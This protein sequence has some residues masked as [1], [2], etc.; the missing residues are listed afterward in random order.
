MA[1]VLK[2][3]YYRSADWL[4]VQPFEIGFKKIAITTYALF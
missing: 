4:K 1:I 2:T 3:V